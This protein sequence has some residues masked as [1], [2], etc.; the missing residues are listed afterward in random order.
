[1]QTNNLRSDRF[2]IYLSKYW[3]WL[4]AIT[5]VW[6]GIQIL[7]FFTRF[8]RLPLDMLI[9]SLYFAPLGF[10]SGLLLLYFVYRAKSTGQRASTIIGYLIA[11]PMAVIGSLLSGLLLPPLIGTVIYG[12]VPLVVGVLIGYTIGKLFLSYRV[13]DSA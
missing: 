4:L 3:P 13:V 9:Q 5:L 7:I 6:P 12:M 1:M 10:L 11:S 8:S 2:F